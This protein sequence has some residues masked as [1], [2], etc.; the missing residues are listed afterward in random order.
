LFCDRSAQDILGMLE[1]ECRDAH[2]EI[3]L[4]TKIQVVERPKIEQANKFKVCTNNADFEAPKL[5]VATGGLSI[6]K[7]GATSLGYDLARQFDLAIRD[8]RPAL[9]PVLLNSEDR[10]HYR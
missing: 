6:P 4:D 8:P 7:M 9:V 10:A 2:V 1:A 3:F 5:V